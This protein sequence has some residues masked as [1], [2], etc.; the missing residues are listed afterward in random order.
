MPLESLERLSSH[1]YSSFSQV[2]ELPVSTR[3]C[4]EW[5]ESRDCGGVEMQESR[6]QSSEEEVAELDMFR[7]AG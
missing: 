6:F 1:C 3:R 4:I 7:E 2:K 5:V